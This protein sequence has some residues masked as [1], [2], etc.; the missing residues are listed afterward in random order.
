MVESCNE[1]ERERFVSQTLRSLDLTTSRNVLEIRLPNPSKSPSPLLEIKTFI[2]PY[3]MEIGIFHRITRPG[4]IFF[5]IP[6]QTVLFPERLMVALQRR[7]GRLKLGATFF[8]RII[9]GEEMTQR[10]GS[11]FLR[12]L[13]RR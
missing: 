4:I 7:K 9:E 11:P 13:L 6:F 5:I 12:L 1:R 8:T 10:D 2:P 3:P